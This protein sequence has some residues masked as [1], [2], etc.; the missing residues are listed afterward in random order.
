M[1]WNDVLPTVGQLVAIAVVTVLWV[2]VSY[3]RQLRS[4]KAYREFRERH[5]L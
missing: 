4:E 1:N 2:A 5:G 3:I